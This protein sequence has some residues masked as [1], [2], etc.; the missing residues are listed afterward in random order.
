MEIPT[1]QAI[2]SGHMIAGAARRILLVIATAATGA[3]MTAQFISISAVSTNAATEPWEV[4]NS[5]IYITFGA[6]RQA[7]LFYSVLA[8]A[9][10]GLALSS[11]SAVIC[12][13]SEMSSVRG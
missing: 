3:V 10:Y 9:E 12:S 1:L 2:P 11:S 4:F 8:R 6:Y 7:I 5:R 13:F